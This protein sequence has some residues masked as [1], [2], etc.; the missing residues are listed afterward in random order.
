VNTESPSAVEAL[1]EQDGAEL[2]AEQERAAEEAAF[3][4]GFGGDADAEPAHGVEDTA[5]G[6]E[7]EADNELPGDEEIAEVLGQQAS[8][9]KPAEDD[10]LTKLEHRLR[11]VEG[12]NGTLLAQNKQLTQRIEAMT[13]RQ[14]PKQPSVTDMLSAA[15]SGGQKLKDLKREF[16]EFA[17]AMDEQARMF[18]ESVDRHLSDMRQQA[19]AA[20][21]RVSRDDAAQMMREAR[22]LARIDSKYPGW[23]R[24]CQ[25]QEFVS[26]Y[27][28]QDDGTKALAQSEE[29]EDAIELLDRYATA[30][31]QAGL[32][33]PNR[34][35]SS[36]GK[37][38]LKG[39]ITA[40]SSASRAAP[41][42]S[43]DEDDFEAGFRSAR[44]G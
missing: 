11:S 8:A 2:A 3:A 22:Q 34:N 10:R 35:V 28:T 25:T 32:T 29:A 39:A 31:Q 7:A 16:P 18:G 17:E 20:G 41:R 37:D 12:R 42:G 40:T 14:D 19:A 9:D 4:R 1:V 15:M 38:R 6:V 26:W 21:D 5:P 24:T 30:M 44:G 13:S 43:S 23:E 33:A 27:G 36:T